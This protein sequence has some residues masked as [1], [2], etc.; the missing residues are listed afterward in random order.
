MADI[1]PRSYVLDG[2]TIPIFITD[3]AL[4]EWEEHRRLLALNGYPDRPPDIDTPTLRSW[5]LHPGEPGYEKDRLPNPSVVREPYESLS[6]ALPRM[7]GLKILVDQNADKQIFIRTRIQ[8]SDGSWLDLGPERPITPEEWEAM[9]ADLLSTAGPGLTNC[10]MFTTHQD[11][12]N[13]LAQS[14]AITHAIDEW[15]TTHEWHVVP[16]A[17]YT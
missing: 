3:D 9:K 11:F 10:L 4:A 1:T 5:I 6:V 7:P 8:E 16:D 14:D 15:Y 13:M 12:E 17:F 2:R